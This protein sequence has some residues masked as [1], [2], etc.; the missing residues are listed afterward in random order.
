MKNKWNFWRKLAKEVRW[1]ILLYFSTIFL[2]LLTFFLHDIPLEVYQDQLLFTLLC[3]VGIIVLTSLKNWQK[4]RLVQKLLRQKVSNPSV[5]LFASSMIEEDYLQM[6][7]AMEK[8]TK[9]VKLV[10]KEQQNELMDFYTLWSHQIKTPLAALDLLIQYKNSPMKKEMTEEIFK[11]QQYLEMMLQV[12][13]LSITEVDFVFKKVTFSELV[14]PVVKEYMNFFI[15][16]KIEL[17]LSDLDE[18]IITDKKWF[19]FILEQV[20]FNAI[21]YTKNG[22]IAITSDKKILHIIDTG[23]GILP[24]DLP[25]IFDKG[26]TGLNGRRHQKASGLGLYISK[27]VAD[28]LGLDLSL[29]SKIDIGTNVAIDARKGGGC[30]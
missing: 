11:I 1:Y 29:T 26:Y 21:K 14:K 19:R 7:M 23:Q 16:K 5:N 8:Q 17:S 28:K 22:R 30:K 6:L 4:H 25:K 20:L 12:L 3:F 15:Q 9:Q 10:V 27:K 13:R 24:E 2:V 18:E